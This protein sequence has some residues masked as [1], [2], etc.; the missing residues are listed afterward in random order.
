MLQGRS[1]R[2]SPGK[3]QTRRGLRGVGFLHARTCQTGAAFTPF[4]LQTTTDNVPPDQRRQ[5]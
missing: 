3:P 1:R 5:G 4:A 2:A